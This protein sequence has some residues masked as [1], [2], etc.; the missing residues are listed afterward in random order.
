MPV[1]ELETRAFVDYL[2]ERANVYAILSFGSSNNLST[3]IAFNPLAVNQTII[4]GWLEPD[5]SECNG[6][7]LY[8]KTTSYKDALNGS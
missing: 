2:F 5:T 1:S 4:T 6:L 8:N 3:P 7:D